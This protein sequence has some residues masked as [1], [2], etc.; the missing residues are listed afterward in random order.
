MDRSFDTSCGGRRGL[1]ER[2]QVKVADAY[3]GTGLGVAA[4]LVFTVASVFAGHAVH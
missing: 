4:V 2:L 3:V 1:V